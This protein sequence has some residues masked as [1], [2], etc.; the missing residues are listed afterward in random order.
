MKIGA[1]GITW[2]DIQITPEEAIEVHRMVR[3]R[4]L[5]PVHW[6]TFNLSHHSWTEPVETLLTASAGAGVN[7]SMPRP[8]QSVEPERPPLVD[9]WWRNAL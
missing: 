8:G 5:M 4:L 1:Y 9:R 6:G 2:P 3:G 7:V